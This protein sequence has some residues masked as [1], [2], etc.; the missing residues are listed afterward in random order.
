MG[1]GILALTLGHT[2]QLK[3]MPYFILMEELEKL[4]LKAL[5][6]GQSGMMVLGEAGTMQGL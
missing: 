2:C 3:P 4:R 5:L 6:W 1:L